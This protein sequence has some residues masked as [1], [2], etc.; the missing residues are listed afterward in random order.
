MEL[1]FTFKHM[2]ATDAIKNHVK[3]QSEK[4]KKFVQGSATANWVF[5]IENE[6]H[7]ADLRVVGPHLDFFGQAKTNDLYQ[8]IDQAVDKVEKQLR[9]HKEILKDHLHRDRSDSE[10]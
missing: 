6:V 10:K 5:Y 9:K 8:S 3:E 1:H 4:L 7:V 2:A